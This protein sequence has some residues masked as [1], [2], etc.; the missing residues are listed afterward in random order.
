[1]L[2]RVDLQDGGV[3]GRA[4]WTAVDRRAAVV[5][6]LV[7]RH[8]AF[9]LVCLAGLIVRVVLVPLGHGQ[10][11][12]VWQLA[13]ASTLRGVNVY[14]HHPAYPGGPYAYFPLFLGLELPLRWLSERTP[15]SFVVLGKLPIVAADFAVAILL[16]RLFLRRGD[17]PGRAAVGAAL[18]VL[19]PLV[20][21]NGA[22]Y[23]RFDVL[24]CALLLAF[25]LSAENGP[26]RGT[27]GYFYYALAVAAKT[28]PVFVAPAALRAAANRWRVLTAVT[29]A[30]L[31]GLSVPYLAAPWPYVRDIVG[32][33]T[34]RIPAGL[35][36][37]TILNGFCSP[38]VAGALSGAGLV[39][40]AAGA[41]IL[42]RRVGHDLDVAMVASLVLF[43]ICSKLVL[44]QYLIWP[45]PWLISIAM[46]GRSRLAT[47]SSVVIVVFTG[48]GLLDNETFHPFG[49]DSPIIGFALAVVSGVYVVISLRGSRISIK[50]PAVQPGTAAPILGTSHGDGR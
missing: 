15:I 9:V 19:N 35:S 4:E 3:E 32:Y 28:F 40:F 20:L 17:R 50:T 10:D 45:M 39:V 13:S 42:A 8:S 21:Y 6:R 31:L 30:V 14:A 5:R 11:F 7:A 24:A 34:G 29:G 26:V 41:V 16:Y 23:G 38:T 37:W 44:E 18:F 46:R 36:W 33:D 22:Y 43:V 48:A 47:A 1:M 2:G 12:M 27:R 25:T 49:R